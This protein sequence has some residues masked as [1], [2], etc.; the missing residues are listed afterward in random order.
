MRDAPAAYS[1]ASRR[2]APWWSRRLADAPPPRS[3]CLGTAPGRPARPVGAVNEPTFRRLGRADFTR[4]RGW[5]ARPHVARWWNH[6]TS[7]S[8]VEADFGPAVDGTEPT[9]L[10]V[11][12]HGRRPVGLLQR[13]TF[14][15]NPGYAAELARLVALPEGALG[16]DYLLGEPDLVGHGLGT[17]MLRAAAAA[18]WRDRPSAPAVVVA[19]N[20]ANRA[21][22][23]AL[24]RAGFERVAEGALEP[25]NPVD[26]SA[27]FVFRIDRPA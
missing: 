15:D 9:E 16:I 11:V 19:V 4:L 13:Y 2:G 1:L 14:A 12:L 7:A 10:F 18:V 22:W 3:A 17:A 21:S 27:H 5:L 24:E 25:D 26:S 20:A 23:R 6:D 8:A